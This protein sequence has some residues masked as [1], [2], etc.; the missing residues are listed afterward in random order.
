MDIDALTTIVGV[1]C[2]T[3]SGIIGYGLGYLDGQSERDD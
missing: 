3:I 1:I 2:I